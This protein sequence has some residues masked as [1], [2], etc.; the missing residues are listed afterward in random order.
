M[1]IFDIVLLILIA[2]A[3]AAAIRKVV[4]DHKN[5]SCCGNCNGCSQSGKCSE[6]KHGNSVYF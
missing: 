6:S 5:G 4:K 3:L 1:N 2:L